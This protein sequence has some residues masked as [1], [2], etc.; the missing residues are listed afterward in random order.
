M[1]ANIADIRQIHLLTLSVP[2]VSLLFAGTFAAIWRQWRESAYLPGLSIA[3]LFHALGAMSQLL[4][5]PADSGQNALVSCLLYSLAVLLFADAC[6]RRVND[7]L[8][9]I[10]GLLALSLILAGCAYFYYVHRNLLARIYVLNFGYGA[11]FLVLAVRL[12][13]SARKKLDHILT[14][15][16]VGV[17]IEF[18]VRTVWSVKDLGTQNSMVTFAR[19]TFWIWL[20]LSSLVLVVLLGIVLVMGVMTDVIERFR[21]QAK[22]DSLT[23][24]LNRRGFEESA[25][26]KLPENTL[27]PISVIAFDLDNFKSINDTYGH[28]AGDFVLESTSRMLHEHIRKGDVVGRIGGEEFII[29]LSNTGKAEAGVFAERIRSTLEKMEFGDDVL[30]PRKITASFGVVEYSPEMSL[31]AIIERADSKLYDAKKTG[32]NRVVVAG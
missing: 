31:R 16:A 7:R 6:L 29:L 24:L 4:H 17:G 2:A 27:H 5:F 12:N 11:I 1:D 25:Q 18:F 30:L 28:A 15:L 20:N 3:F 23:G 21:L 32:R 19:S 14:W 9:K 13:R 8:P 22:V 26:A 10:F